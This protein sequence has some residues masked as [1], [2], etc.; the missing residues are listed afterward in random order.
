MNQN[1]SLRIFLLF[2]LLLLAGMRVERVSAHGG[3]P[4]LEISAD[5]VNPGGVVD[6]RG[7]DFEADTSV[8]LTLVG[9]Q[10]TIWLGETGT[11]AEGSFLQTVTLPVDLPEGNYTFS[12]LHDDRQ[13]VSPALIVYGTAIVEN[14]ADQRSEEDGL[15]APMPTAGAVPVTQPAMSTPAVVEPAA[16]PPYGLFALMTVIGMGSL[17]WWSLWRKRASG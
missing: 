17:L 5:R 3:E 12:V 16:P 7:V 11:D 15:L 1:I 13:I 4:R 6:V 10:Q 9:P 14:E 8:A 2:L